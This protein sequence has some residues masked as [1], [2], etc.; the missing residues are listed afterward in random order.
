M[1]RKA[2]PAAAAATAA[3]GT[4][5]EDLSIWEDSNNNL[6]FTPLGSGREVGR[7]CH[8]LEFK[9]KRILLDCGIHPGKE[10][11]ELLPFFDRTDLS[12]ID[13]CLITHFHLDHAASL[14]YLTERTSF[15]GQVFM[16]SCT[17]AILRLVLK[18]YVRILAHDPNN[19]PLYTQE[20]L[21]R[22]LERC[23]TVGL[24]QSIEIEGIKI[25]PYLAGH[26]LGAAMFMLEI[27]GVRILYTG[28]YSREDDRHLPGAE[29]P[30]GRP[31][32]LIVE[33]TFGVLV[34]ESREE[35]EKRFTDTV[36]M[37][38]RRGGNCLIPMGALGA[39]QELLLILED[40]WNK[41]PDLRGINIYHTSRIA[42]EA[43]KVYK[44]FI[45]VMNAEMRSRQLSDPWNLQNIGSLG[46]NEVI[47]APAVVLASPGYLQSGTSRRLFELWCSDRR[48]GVILAGYSVE[49]TLAKEL[50]KAGSIKEIESLNGTM[51]TVDC[52]IKTIT[53]AAHSDYPGTKSFVDQ[54][55]PKNII[56]VH[57]EQEQ[58][59]KLNADLSRDPTLRELGTNIYRPHNGE[60][61][62]LKFQEQRIVKAYGG[63]LVQRR[64]R[65]PG[66]RVAAYLVRQDLTDRFISTE[67]L[68]MYTQLKTARV[69]QRLHIP[70]H[71]TFADLRE[72]VGR[73]FQCEDVDTDDVKRAGSSILV[74]GHVE[75][76]LQKS[77]VRLTWDASP[78][79]D[80]VADALMAILL[81]AESGMAA[82]RIGTCCSAHGH[83]AHSHELD[84]EAKDEVPGSTE[85]GLSTVDPSRARATSIADVL[86]NSETALLL[87]NLLEER[88]GTESIRREADHLIITDGR[89]EARVDL[90]TKGHVFKFA[91]LGSLPPAAAD[92]AN[93]KA[94]D[95]SSVPHAERTTN[96]DAATS[97]D[98]GGDASK[99]E[100]VDPA[101]A[102]A[103][104]PAPAPAPVLAL[105][106]QVDAAGQTEK[107]PAS[108]FEIALRETIALAAQT[109]HPVL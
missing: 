97:H 66:T 71:R 77:L 27:A 49:G 44:A 9:G 35:R 34:H 5:E 86:K 105:P 64:M 20:Q 14:P 31:D 58:M 52:D 7:S 33:A 50:S 84:Q 28:D 73:V 23:Q 95:V 39:V 59:R 80:M 6:K 18:D 75:V 61:V 63:E 106:S 62:N 11:D 13:I 57:G 37:I 82:V 100:D 38:V 12:K 47:Q 90:D 45:N 24:H 55:R 102:T 85:V 67:D 21:T 29:I 43:L 72:A 91:M 40:H 56:L 30:S 53:F 10:G 107:E 48:N 70:F 81:Q 42:N 96:M 101:T 104:A 54:L 79:N 69:Q 93:I 78:S 41:N 89:Q 4:E 26:V 17:K 83:E 36:E 16:T 74:N 92:D 87:L 51:L 3:P 108:D 46:E 68:R 1:K 60:P 22:C 109:V 8:V 65:T 25:T 15:K 32:V 76:F 98:T 103:T 19:P 88:F 99:P 2:E 94:H